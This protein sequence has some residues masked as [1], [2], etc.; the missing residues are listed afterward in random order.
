MIETNFIF[1]M[2]SQSS[3]VLHVIFKQCVNVNEHYI[4]FRETLLEPDEF[5]QQTSGLSCVLFRNL[6]ENLNG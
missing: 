2:R 1:L 4:G 3:H 5:L 6:A